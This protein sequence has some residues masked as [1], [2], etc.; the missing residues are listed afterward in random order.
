MGVHLVSSGISLAEIQPI[1]RTHV[2]M[3]RERASGL[4]DLDV[5]HFSKWYA[6]IINGDII[7]LFPIILIHIFPHL[8][9]MQPNWISV[10]TDKFI[11]R[12]AIDC[13]AS[14]TPA[15]L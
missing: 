7:K 8:I 15:L 2:V 11:Y 5:I 12:N 6:F 3:R 14:S 4:M 9:L 13:G 10:S 1:L